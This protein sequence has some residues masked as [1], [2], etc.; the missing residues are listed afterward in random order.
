MSL[1]GVNSNY[2]NRYKMFLDISINIKDLR[3]F[4]IY[5]SIKIKK[6]I[7]IIY[8]YINKIHKTKTRVMK[9]IGYPCNSSCKLRVCKKYVLYLNS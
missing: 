4:L 5:L 6:G 3:I 2:N 8:L 7:V 1:K 9:W